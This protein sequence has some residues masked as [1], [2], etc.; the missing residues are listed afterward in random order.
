[1]DGSG[2]NPSGYVTFVLHSHLPYVI[3]H[4]TWPH[5]EDWLYE[6][7]AETYLPILRILGELEQRGAALKANINLSPVLLEQLAHPRFKAGFPKYLQQKL[8]AARQDAREFGAQGEG[9]MVQVAEFWQRFYAESQRD[10]DAIGQ[11]IIGAFKRFY[12][13]GA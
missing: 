9:H 2:T 3:N 12:D 13:A 11:N 8:D 6:A 1:M 4:G 7:A 10:F 5:G